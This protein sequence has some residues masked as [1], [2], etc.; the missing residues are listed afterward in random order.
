MVQK[1]FYIKKTQSSIFLETVGTALLLFALPIAMVYSSKSSPAVFI[2]ALICLLFSHVRTVGIHAAL[3]DLFNALARP[4][5]WLGLITSIFMLLSICWS[6]M[7]WYGFVM[8][9]KAISAI[10]ALMLWSIVDPYRNRTFDTIFL[11]MGIILAAIGITLELFSPIS[12]RNWIGVDSRPELMNRPMVTLSIYMCLLMIVLIKTTRNIW[13]LMMGGCLMMSIMM[14]VSQTDSQTSIIFWLVFI[15]VLLGSLISARFMLYIT[16]GGT[17]FF[18]IVFPFLIEP[19]AVIA[20]ALDQSNVISGF[21]HSAHF[22]ER[23]IL[24]RDY[25][26][27]IKEHFVFGWG[28]GSERFISAPSLANDALPIGAHVHPHSFSLHIWV[29]FGMLGIVIATMGLLQT[30]RTLRPFQSPE[31]HF[32]IA[33]FAGLLAIWS[34]SHGAWQAWWIVVSGFSAIFAVRYGRLESNMSQSLNV[35]G[36]K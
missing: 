6:L 7:P 21:L 22:Q 12:I 23:I 32:L 10:I 29:S 2:S 31:I 18:I 17:I 14:L 9:L 1:D 25:A 34:I 11:T 19:I 13:M 27:I 24:W 20:E 4:W 26:S 8:A 3:D 15:S 5:I 36:T 28:I 33:L 30:A 16:F 35:F